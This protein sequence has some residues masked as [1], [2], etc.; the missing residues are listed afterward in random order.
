M[1]AEQKELAGQL[2]S[3]AFHSRPLTS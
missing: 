2:S 3:S 1:N